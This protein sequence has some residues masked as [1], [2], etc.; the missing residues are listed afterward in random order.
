MR[1]INQMPFTECEKCKRCVLSVKD[2][3]TEY[4]ERVLYVSCRYAQK[5]F[6]RKQKGETA[7]A[8]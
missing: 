2:N 3:V 8:D 1:I 5:C 6:K 4:G 7:N